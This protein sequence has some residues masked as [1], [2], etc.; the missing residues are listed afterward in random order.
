MRIGTDVGGTFTD[1][2]IQDASTGRVVVRK[3]PSTPSAPDSSIIEGIRGILK[4]GFDRDR[5]Q[6][7]A[8]GNTIAT[9]AVIERS[10]ATVGVLTTKGFRDVLEIGRLARPPG[11]LNDLFL[12]LPA[13]LVRRAYRCEVNERLDYAGKVIRPLDTGE[14]RKIAARLASLDVT[15]VAVCFLFSYLD[16]RHERLTAEVLADE[17]PDVAVTLSSDVLPEFREYER[18]STT[19]LHA[20]V[21]PLIS[22][23]LDHLEARVR[24]DLGLSCPVYVLQSNGG[25]SSVAITRDRPGTMLLS[26]PSGG[27]RAAG[28]LA[29]E[30]GFTNIITADMGGTSFDVSVIENGQP[31]ITESRSVL[32]QPMRESMV[33]IETIGAGGGS[34]AWVDDAG[35]LHVGPRSAGAEPGPACYGKGGREATVTDANVALGLLSAG[36]VLGSGVRF[37]GDFAADACARLGRRLGMSKTEA[38][39]GIRTV[40][41]AAMAGAIRAVTVRRGHDP[42][43]F[44]LLAYG[45]AGPLHAADLMVELGCRWLLIPENP[46]CFSAEGA[47]LAD[48]THAY[49]QSVLRDLST[50]K[51]GDVENAFMSLERRANHDLERDGIP[52][53]RRKMMRSLELR[54]QGQSH[55][56]KIDVREGAGP[57]SRELIA[58]A[59]DAF[60]AEHERLYTFAV[61]DAAVELVG[62]RLRAIG[63]LERSTSPSSMGARRARQSPRVLRRI[64]SKGAWHDARVFDRRNLDTGTIIQGPALI[65]QTDTTIIVPD[66]LVATVHQIGAL[67]IGGHEYR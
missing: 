30:L 67:V 26:G 41:N 13:P 44:C 14:I 39:A 43:D 6:L 52:R 45:G 12:S 51:P 49:V 50:L 7:I 62:T 66:D 55:S 40:I 28:V 8:H 16:P 32:E 20:Y 59:V 34:I 65:E 57:A 42:K 1:I 17:L 33:E 35:G 3:V 54:Y 4:G 63:F 60:H 21:K 2:V 31:S 22:G 10:G 19:V 23:Y 38:A 27:V 61:H 9:N 53:D 5:V 48:L 64:F 46:G 11:Y 37:D 56:L 58:E 18:S 36:V 25:L 47:L 24:N 29:G 15:S